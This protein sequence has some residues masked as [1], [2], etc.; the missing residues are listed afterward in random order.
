MM[1]TAFGTTFTNSLFS[2]RYS[3]NAY[4]GTHYHKWSDRNTETVIQPFTKNSM[5]KLRDFIDYPALL[6]AVYKGKLTPQEA[7][8][9]YFN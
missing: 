5:P 8:T 2:G 1:V 4:E 3:N 6:T 9:K 7:L